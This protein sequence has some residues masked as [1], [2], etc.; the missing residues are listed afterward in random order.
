MARKDNVAVEGSQPTAATEGG[1]TGAVRG[2]SQREIVWNRFKRHRLAVI[3][4]FILV[5]LYL[6]AIA[7]P[8]IAPYGYAEIDYTAINQGPSLAHPM[9]ADNLGRDELTR[10]IYGGRVSLLVGLSVGVFSTVLGAAVGIVAGFYGRF[11]DTIVMAV[12][13]FWLTLPFLAVLLVL[14]A[15]FQ[16]TPVTISIVLVLILWPPIARLVR[17]E[18]LSLRGQEYV[19]AAKAIGVSGMRTMLRHIL[20][21]TIG[22]M[23]VQATLITAEAILI[24]SVLSFLGLGIQPPTPSWGNMLA[25]ARTTITLY[26]WLAIFPGLMII[27][28]ALSV[29]FLGDGLRDALDPQATE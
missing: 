8:F 21:N 13:D 19:Q 22:I 17:G 10:V 4:G 29:N 25:D 1:Q 26:P 6:A 27:I 5:G 23:L 2:R 18:V 9:G 12:T 15:I 24:E 3:C 16:F 11:V 28:T 7:A 14:G 20:P